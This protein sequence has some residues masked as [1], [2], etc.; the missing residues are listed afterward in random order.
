[1]GHKKSKKRL[2]MTVK[3]IMAEAA[4]ESSRTYIPPA[5][6]ISPPGGQRSTERPLP[7]DEKAKK[8]VSR[9]FLQ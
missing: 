6:Q 5:T 3:Q 2:S 9:S 8:M 4:S 1:M 7:V